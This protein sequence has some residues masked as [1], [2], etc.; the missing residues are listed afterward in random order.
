MLDSLIVRRVLYSGGVVIVYR[1]TVVIASGK[2]PVTFRTRKLRLIAPMVL[3][4]GG[5]G[6][7]GHRRTPFGGGRDSLVC[8]VCVRLAGPFS[9]FVC[10]RVWWVFAH[11]VGVGGSC[12]WGPFFCTQNTSVLGSAHHR[13]RQRQRRATILSLG[14]YSSNVSYRELYSQ[15]QEVVGELIAD[16]D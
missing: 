15:R 16:C 14:S 12:W 10:A 7:V 1:V 11:L 9:F 4:S 2:R 5:C 8:T 13:R 3:H 6:R